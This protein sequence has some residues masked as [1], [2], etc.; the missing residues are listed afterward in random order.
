MDDATVHSLP[1]DPAELKQLL[2]AL[3]R[4][5]ENRIAELQEQA[6]RIE[7][8]NQQIRLEIQRIESLH[9]QQI[10]ELE[11]DKLRLQQQLLVAM[12]KLYGPR[13]DRLGWFKAFGFHCRR[14]RDPYAESPRS[15]ARQGQG[16]ALSTVNVGPWPA[17]TEAI[18]EATAEATKTL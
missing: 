5:H 17:L 14:L 3:G 8:Q 18:A 16:H 1:D 11:L 9:Q 10:A 2:L 7:L 6:R 4:K 15:S 13:G 12:K